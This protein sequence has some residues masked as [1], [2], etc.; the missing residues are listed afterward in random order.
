MC[1]HYFL[2]LTDHRQRNPLLFCIIDLLCYINLYSYAKYQYLWQLYVFRDTIQFLNFCTWNYLNST[3]FV[4]KGRGNPWDTFSPFWIFQEI[5]T[6]KIS[7]RLNFLPLFTYRCAAIMKSFTS[8][9]TL[10][11][12]FYFINRNPWHTE[13]TVFIYYDIF[14]RYFIGAVQLFKPL[15]VSSLLSFI[16]VF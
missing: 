13:I 15:R 6:V 10:L 3:Y 1:V 12:L 4:I 2:K 16:T 7:I 9:S 5:M 11:L 14:I 8:H